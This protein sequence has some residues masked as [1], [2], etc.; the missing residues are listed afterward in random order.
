MSLDLHS[1]MNIKVKMFEFLLNF[2]Q[3]KFG[4]SAKYLIP[5]ISIVNFTIATHKFSWKYYLI[6]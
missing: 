5:F 6:F 4:I 3:H 2:Q 1:L